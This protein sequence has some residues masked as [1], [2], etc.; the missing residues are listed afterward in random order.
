MWAHIVLPA[1][2]EGDEG[3]APPGQAPAVGALRGF[4]A[5]RRPSADP[6]K[7]AAPLPAAA[8]RVTRGARRRLRLR[9]PRPAAAR[10]APRSRG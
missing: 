7:P 10:R 1:L 5:L 4:A 3:A 6:A 2:G 8:R 9:G